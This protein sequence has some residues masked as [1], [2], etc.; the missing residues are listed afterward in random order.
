MK[1]LFLLL[2]LILLSLS[3]YSQNLKKLSKDA[4]KFA[5]KGEYEQCVKTCEL[6]LVCE[7]TDIE[8][9]EF[10]VFASNLSYE[11]CRIQDGMQDKIKAYQFG[12]IA[13]NLLK[14][15]APLDPNYVNSNAKMVSDIT[16][17]LAQLLKEN[18][19][20][21]AQIA[22]STKEIAI[23]NKPIESTIPD[24][25]ALTDNVTTKQNNTDKIVTITVSGSGKSQDEA[26][27]SALRSAIEQAFGA[28]ISA[29][30]EI[31]NDQVVSDQ[32]T[33]VASGNIQ[34]FDVLN[35]SQLPDGTW[36]VTLKALVS[37]SKLTSFVEA[38]GVAVEIKGGLF[39][40]NIKQQILNEQA[41]FKAVCDMVGLLH[42]P[43]QTAFDY[44]VKSGEPKSIDSESKNWEIPLTVTATANKNLDFCADYTIK[45][46]ASLSLSTEEVATY[47]SLNKSVLPIVISYNGNVQTFYLRKKSSINAL[48]TLISQWG[49]YT[50]LFNVQS[51]L[52][53]SNGFGEGNIHNFGYS[54][55]FHDKESIIT[56]LTSGKQ[57]AIFSWQDKRTLAQIEQI[58]GYTVKPRGVVSQF[59]HGGFVIYE[60]DGHGLV[61]AIMDCGAFDLNSAK[62]ACDEFIIN[63][64]SDWR[65]PTKDELNTIYI[66]LK[67]SGVGNFRGTTEPYFGYYWSSIDS[68][69]VDLLGYGDDRIIQLDGKYSLPARAVRDF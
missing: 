56:Y 4:T 23:V 15:V 30:T 36:G 46:L 19:N 13:L 6:I 42:E 63:G 28:F 65:L 8:T 35:A 22:K 20:V 51:G 66:N 55:D 1:N 40:L 61:A 68:W 57:A 29:K 11:Y 32:I 26:K 25:S 37:V 21:N 52:D 54:E 45:T 60:K 59:K 7:K 10:K 5:E 24:K 43:M 27:Q 12:E 49:F 34:S 14:Q 3:G 47:K 62:T 38:K 41:E 9:L 39:A 18:P 33:S 50:R 17:G 58:T 44:T 2:T 48:N 69:A 16:N 53:E 31:L 64:Y 67:L